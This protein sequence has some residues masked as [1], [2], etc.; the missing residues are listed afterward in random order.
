VSLGDLSCCVPAVRAGESLG[1]ISETR[2]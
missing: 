1:Q 2:H